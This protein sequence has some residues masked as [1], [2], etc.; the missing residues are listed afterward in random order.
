MF[1]DLM[2]KLVF[3]IFFLNMT[4]KKK[5]TMEGIAQELITEEGENF[6]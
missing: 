1:T 3:T 2:K 4:Q 6:P 5:K